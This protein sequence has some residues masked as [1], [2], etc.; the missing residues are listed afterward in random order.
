MNAR[1]VGRRFRFFDGGEATG[2][3]GGIGKGTAGNS[4]VIGIANFKGRN[5]N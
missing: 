2:S 1:S 5:E 4:F 3:R